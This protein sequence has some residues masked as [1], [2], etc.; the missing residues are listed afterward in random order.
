MPEGALATSVW[1]CLL[2]NSVLLVSSILINLDPLSLEAIDKGISDR[3]I[4]AEI[5]YE[6]RKLGSEGMGIDTIIGSGKNKTS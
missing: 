1:P 3:E 2:L 5:E 6:M 4:A